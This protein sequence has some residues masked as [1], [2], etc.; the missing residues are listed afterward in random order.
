MGQLMPPLGFWQRWCPCA[1]CARVRRGH[2]LIDFREWKIGEHTADSPDER[3]YLWV[4]NGQQSFQDYVGEPILAG[5]SWLEKQ[6]I[7]WELK[8]E[9]RRRTR[10][11]H[12][13]NVAEAQKGWKEIMLRR[14]YPTEL[15]GYSETATGPATFTYDTTTTTS[16]DVRAI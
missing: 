9:I 11:R 15:M 2:P 13:H 12:Q 8:A 7:W 14:A 5:F 16:H 1:K 10:V 4:G 6:R 3:S